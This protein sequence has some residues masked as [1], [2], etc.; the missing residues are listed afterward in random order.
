[1]VLQ[2]EDVPKLH[3][4]TNEFKEWYGPND[5]NGGTYVEKEDLLSHIVA[6]PTVLKSP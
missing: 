1:M 5:D 6:R 2:T 3:P 4:G